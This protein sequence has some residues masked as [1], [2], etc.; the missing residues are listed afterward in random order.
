MEQYVWRVKPVSTSSLEMQT[1]LNELDIEG[2]EIFAIAPAP[3]SALR[4]IAR[5]PRQ[6]TAEGGES[7]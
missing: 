3:S 2:W 7:C 5:R 4:L 6:P 1:A